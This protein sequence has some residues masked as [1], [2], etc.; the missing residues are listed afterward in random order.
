MSQWQPE[1]QIAALKYGAYITLLCCVMFGI[2]LLD[3]ILTDVTG[4]SYML[5]SVASGLSALAFLIVLVR[6]SRK[7]IGHGGWR[8]IFGLYSEEFAHDLNR[9]ATSYACLALLVMLL[10]AHVLAD[11][12]F[13]SKLGT[14]MQAIFSLNN[15]SLLLLLVAG[16]VWAVTVLLNLRDEAED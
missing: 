13:L 6:W 16:V 3:T 5:L 11:P 7:G 2:G 12:I 15:F 14:T 1:Q 10:L 4:K 8:E 9:K